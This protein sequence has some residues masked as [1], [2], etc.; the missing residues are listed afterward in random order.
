MNVRIVEADLQDLGH[1]AALVHIV[2]SY[3]RGPGGQGAPLSAKARDN[4]VQGLAEHPAATVLLALQGDEP[5]GVAVC[6]WSFSTFAGQPSVNIHD[7]AVLPEHQGRGVGRSLLGDVERRARERGC[8]K[9][10][11]E[12]HDSNEGAKR[13]YA[14]FGFGSFDSPTLFVT[15]PIS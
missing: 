12:V 4:L 14:S 9:I 6:V 2:D 11:L 5:I 7:L 3:A 10:T 8:A 1:G 15:K 13:L